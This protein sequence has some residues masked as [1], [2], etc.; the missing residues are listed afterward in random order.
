VNRSLL[1]S[2]EERGK[3]QHEL[4][5]IQERLNEINEGSAKE[6]AYRDELDTMIRES[7]D[8]F[9]KILES[10]QTLL[11]VVR[12]EQVA[13]KSRIG[14]T[15]EAYAPTPGYQPSYSPSPARPGSSSS[16]AAASGGW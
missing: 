5:R 12:R 13:M 7:E 16:A 10:S 15:G 1:R 3:L 4:R 11:A 14:D 8:A 6:V 9:M 2:E